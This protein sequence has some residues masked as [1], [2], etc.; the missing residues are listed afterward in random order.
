LVYFLAPNLISQGLS[1]IPY[2]F[3][4]WDLGHLD[5]LEFPETAYNRE[6]EIRENIYLNSLKK[7]I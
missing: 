1:N 4:L 3:T 7:S 2:V 5:T 6:F